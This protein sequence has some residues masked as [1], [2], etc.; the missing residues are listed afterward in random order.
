MNFNEKDEK[1]ANKNEGFCLSWVPF[2]FQLVIF[3]DIS[4]NWRKQK[5]T[6]DI[7]S[8]VFWDLVAGE[9]FEPTT[10]GL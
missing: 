10:S 7:D 2:G 3:V 4:N 1:S 6:A 5:N 8:A 9:G